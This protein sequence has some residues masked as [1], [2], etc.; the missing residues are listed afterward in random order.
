MRT[1]S[2][3]QL[4]GLPEQ[5]R[6]FLKSQKGFRIIEVEQ[7]RSATTPVAIENLVVKIDCFFDEAGNLLSKK[8][9]GTPLEQE[10]NS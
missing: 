7:V 5:T 8:R 9:E 1:K 4:D 3:A 6:S 2:P 10:P